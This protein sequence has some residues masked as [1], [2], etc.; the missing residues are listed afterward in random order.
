MASHD[1][2]VDPSSTRINSK[3]IPFGSATPTIASCNNGR[4]S[5]SLNTGTQID[6]RGIRSCW[7]LAISYTV[8]RQLAL[9]PIHQHQVPYIRDSPRAPDDPHRIL[10]S[11]EVHQ[12]H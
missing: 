5:A 11:H 4:F 8:P 7:L 12:L 6:N 9:L 1:P 10:L 3:S 2:S